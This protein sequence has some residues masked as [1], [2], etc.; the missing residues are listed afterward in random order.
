M[1][2]INH[3]DYSIS[4]NKNKQ[5]NTEDFKNLNQ[6]VSFVEEKLNSAIELFEKV[7][8]DTIDAAATDAS[9]TKAYS[10]DE[11]L[12]AINLLQSVFSWLGYYMVKSYQPINLEIIRLIPHVK[13][14][15]WF[16]SSN[17]SNHLKINTQ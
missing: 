13:P 9:A 2:L 10:T 16:S 4:I 6:F 1:C 14:Y 17:P 8:E 12:S 15:F 3:I 7:S 11:H 5:F